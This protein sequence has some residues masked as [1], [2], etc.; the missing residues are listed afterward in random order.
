LSQ[1]FSGYAYEK[2][3]TVWRVLIGVESWKLYQSKDIF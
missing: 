1:S 3:R 2:D